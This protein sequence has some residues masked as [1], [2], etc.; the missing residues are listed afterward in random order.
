MIRRRTQSFLIYTERSGIKVIVRCGKIFTLFFVFLALLAGCEKAPKATGPQ[1]GTA[2]LGE[3]QV[4]YR[5]GV[6]PLHNPKKLMDSYQPLM[7][8]LNKNIP[9]VQFVLEAS[10]DYSIFEEKYKNR[11]P[12]FILP[13][14]WQTLGA[15]QS[16]YSV[17]AMA[18]DPADFKGVII[19]RKDSGIKEPTD[20]KGKKVSY[21]SPT[22][23]AACI[24]PQYYLHTHGVD[25]TKDI[26]NLYVG[27]QESSIMNV[28]L[29]T[30]AAGAT[31]PQPW[32]DFQKTHPKEAAELMTIWETESLVNNSVMVLDDV[33]DSIKIQVENILV[34][35]NQTEE[36][37]QIL[38]NLE[39]DYFKS[40]TNEDYHV[41][42]AFTDRFER[43]VR[44]IEL[45]K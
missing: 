22:A 26:T 32:R 43:E 31:W 33:P 12:E 16:G 40:A 9:G 5:F 8:Y 41:V 44:K 21:P 34:Q 17:I 14:P 20:L 28:Y 37:N 11:K 35:L 24:L 38:L 2:P 6:H 36:G 4:I 18:G 10:R 30:T 27:S 19:V 3:A 23:L 45:G 39:T 42:Q 7:D 13:N 15:I 25:V 29:K 1:Y